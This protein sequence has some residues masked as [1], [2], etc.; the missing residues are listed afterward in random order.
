MR[1]SV[2]NLEQQFHTDGGWLERR[3]GLD[4]EG[5]L[6]DRQHPFERRVGI[7][8]EPGGFSA[9][10][11]TGTPLGI[12][13]HDVVQALDLGVVEA[14]EADVREIAWVIQAPEQQQDA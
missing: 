4:A 1:R 7:V 13:D 8:V 5:C 14:G 6:R 2:T 11:T 12:F 3:V 10:T 9:V